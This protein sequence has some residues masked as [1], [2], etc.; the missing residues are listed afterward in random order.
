MSRTVNDFKIGQTS[1][2]I[3]VLT[4]STTPT[5]EFYL[6]QYTTKA[7]V[8]SQIQSISYSGGTTH[9]DEAIQFARNN[10]FTAQHGDR[11][12]APNFVIILT[13]GA[14]ADENATLVEARFLKQQGVQVIAI[15][16]GDSINKAEL[17]GMASDKSHVFE[18]SSFDALRT[19]REDLKLAGCEGM[20]NHLH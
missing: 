9:T 3:G 19:I 4:F 12:D 11:A 15:G 5:L 2:Q 16:I 7:Q 13:D 1:V 17:E 14:S 20:F 6:N 8:L 18:V 10:M